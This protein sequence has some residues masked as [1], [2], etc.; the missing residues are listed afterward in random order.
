[1]LPKG[2]KRLL[3]LL[4][5]VF[6]AAFP[7]LRAHASSSARRL[8]KGLRTAQRV[9]AAA[10]AAAAEEAA[11][12]APPATSPRGAPSPAPSP[13]PPYRALI[14]IHKLQHGTE[15]GTEYH[16][17]FQYTLF[18]PDGAYPVYVVAD[19]FLSCH[20]GPR[21]IV[22]MSRHFQRRPDVDHGL[23]R[24]TVERPGAAP[25]PLPPCE[26]YIHTHYET[27]AIGRCAFDGG[28]LCEAGAAERSPPPPPLPIRVAYN[29]SLE[30]V[31][32]LGAPPE[33][34]P[35]DFAMVA[36]FNHYS[37]YFLPLWLAYWRAI[38]VDTFYLFFNG[39]GE[40]LPHLQAMVAGFEGSVVIVKVRGGIWRPRSAH[41]CSP[42]RAHSPTIP[43]HSPSPPAV[44]NAALDPHGHSRQHLWAAHR[45]Q[46]RGGSLAPPPQVDRL[47]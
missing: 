32:E 47:L 2:T 36:V 35:S 7:A 22:L 12:E 44:G 24:V 26:W 15:L 34:P 43:P 16:P 25:Q 5:L 39:N 8:M 40:E 30:A 28:A 37:S 9:A 4:A 10:A 42:I 3:L 14:G 20:N 1:M 18:P 21:A 17:Y 19:A 33:P 23:L 11:R 38:G 46:L 45:H 31:F 29:G 27:V 6:F 41:G 13:S